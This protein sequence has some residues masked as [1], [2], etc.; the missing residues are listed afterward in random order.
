MKAV[1]ITDN[2]V[3]GYNLTGDGLTEIELDDCMESR[4]EINANELSEQWEEGYLPA[5]KRP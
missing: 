2:G 4:I 1:F 3:Y 5:L